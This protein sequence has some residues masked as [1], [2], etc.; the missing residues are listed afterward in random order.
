MI[1]VTIGIGEGWRELAQAAALRMEEMTGIQCFVIE[2]NPREWQAV[3]PSWL[4]CHVPAMFPDHD[5]FLV[6]DA[7]I[8]AVRPWDPAALFETLGRPFMAVPE[9]GTN[10]E[11]MEECR[12]WQLAFPDSYLNCGLLVFGR[13][14]APVLDAAWEYHPH[15]GE[16]LE[17][18]ALNRALVDSGVEICR[19]P[20]RYNTL[21]KHGRINSIYSRVSPQDAVCLHTAAMADPR[22]ILAHHRRLAAWFDSGLAG[23]DRFDWLQTLPPGSVGAEIGVFRGDFSRQILDVVEPATLHLVDLFEGIIISGDEHG[24]HLREQDMS[25]MPEELAALGSAVQVHRSDSAAWL[26]AQPAAS[27][28]WCYIDAAHD[29]DHVLADLRAAAHAVKPGGIIAGHDFSRAFPGVMEAVFT[30]LK[31]NKGTIE[32]F[33]GDLLPSYAIRNAK[34]S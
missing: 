26:L 14:H 9:P 29:H 1:G 3:H 5:E 31:E 2:E 7:D 28:D 25:T 22:E 11:V 34:A 18:T 15:G 30:F 27:L 23:R 20:R 24:R 21:A 33:D 6:F 12:K 16:W 17:Q 32:I 19:L 8:L 13:E 10:P 4:K